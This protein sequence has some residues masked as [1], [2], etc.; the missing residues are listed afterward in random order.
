M[1]AERR[2]AAQDQRI[3]VSEADFL[4]MTHDGAYCNENGE[5]GAV[6]FEQVRAAAARGQDS[7]V[8]PCGRSDRLSREQ[9]E[10]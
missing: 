6:E 9:Y 8:A 5:V 2:G 10:P 4:T 7:T 3:H 1:G